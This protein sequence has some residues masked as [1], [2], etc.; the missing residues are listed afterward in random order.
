MSLSG[1]GV[2]PVAEK[3]IM[4]QTSVVI[5]L[6]ISLLKVLPIAEALAVGFLSY[7]IFQLRISGRELQLTGAFGLPECGM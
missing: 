1:S 7:L 4:C 5:G 6:E 2:V 3:V